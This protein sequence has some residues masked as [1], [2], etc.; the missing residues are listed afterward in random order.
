MRQAEHR[1]VDRVA[2]CAGE[3]LELGVEQPAPFLEQAAPIEHDVVPEDMALGLRQG[4]ASELHAPG[5]GDAGGVIRV[6]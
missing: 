6:S 4:D 3:H 5:S 2:A 1:D